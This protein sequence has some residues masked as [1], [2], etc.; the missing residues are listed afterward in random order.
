LKCLLAASK[1]DTDNADLRDCVAR[2][3]KTRKAGPRTLHPAVLP[4]LFDFFVLFLV[5]FQE[6]GD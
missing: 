2:F 6:T 3:R 1:I 4:L 5:S